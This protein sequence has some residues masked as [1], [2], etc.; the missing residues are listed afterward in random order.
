M[1]Y[2]GFTNPFFMLLPLPIVY[3]SFANHPH[4]FYYI[5]HIVTVAINYPNLLHQSLTNHYQSN[6]VHYITSIPMITSKL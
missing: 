3:Q 2:Q 4:A 1:D 5:D 6:P